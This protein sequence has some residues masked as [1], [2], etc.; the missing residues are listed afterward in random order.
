MNLTG[1]T[2]DGQTVHLS[3]IC[4]QPLSPDNSAC[5]VF[6]V[7]QYFQ[8]KQDNFMKCVTD[9]EEPCGPDAIGNIAEDWHD[10][11]LGCSRYF[12]N[13]LKL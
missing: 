3:D 1:I 11:I 6:S 8:L 9:L 7:M 12:C 2:P 13:L 10:Q 5:T 4:L